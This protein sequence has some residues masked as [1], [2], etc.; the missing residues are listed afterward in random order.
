[1]TKAEQDE[2]KD[3]RKSGC[4]SCK[5]GL[6]EAAKT[7]LFLSQRNELPLRCYDMI[8]QSVSLKSYLL[9]DRILRM[10]KVYQEFPRQEFPLTS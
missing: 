6:I 4:S 8:E 2:R 10:N 3:K 5:H 1:M 9:Y 7:S